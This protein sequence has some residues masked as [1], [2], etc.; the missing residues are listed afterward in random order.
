MNPS[1][2][3]RALHAERTTE[4]VDAILAIPNVVGVVL[5][6]S[7][8]RQAAWPLS[9]ID[10]VPIW[11]DGGVA[12]D[13]LDRVQAGLVDW[14][15]SSGRAQTLD[16]GWIAFEAREVRAV[17]DGEPDYPTLIDDDRWFHGLDKTY[18]GIG[19]G[20]TI[21]VDLG[22]FATAVR[23]D[24]AH[25]GARLGSM[26]R[27]WTMWERMAETH[28][29]DTSAIVAL[30]NADTGRALERAERAPLWLKER[31]RLSLIGREAVGETV[32][33]AQNA[34]DQLAAFEVHV[35]KRNEPPFAGWLDLPD[36]DWVAKRQRLDEL[37]AT[38]TP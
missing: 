29:I 31:I 9:D 6:G 16:V 38:L 34:R 10:L 26:G 32:S 36:P 14:W 11:R 15:A 25:R 23:F 21:A 17:V 3:W 30:A 18:R 13:E 33:A 24:P 8:A 5:G 27:E 7:V 12:R 28:G 20:A 4:A 1:E 2:S 19:F 35:A 22:A 37:I